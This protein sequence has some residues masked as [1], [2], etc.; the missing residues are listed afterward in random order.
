MEGVKTE[1]TAIGTLQTAGVAAVCYAPQ[2]HINTAF[3]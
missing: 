1:W 3:G 2:I